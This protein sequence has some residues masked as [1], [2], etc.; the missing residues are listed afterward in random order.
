M[1]F[2]LIPKS[3]TLNDLER[4]IMTVI[5]CFFSPNSV[6]LRADYVKVV[7]DRPTQCAT[8]MYTKESSF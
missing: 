7:E 2:R 8:Q 6:D 4:L 1:G 5:L 3:V